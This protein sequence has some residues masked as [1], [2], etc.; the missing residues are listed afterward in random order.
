M[1]AS[2]GWL[3]IGPRLQ[4]SVDDLIESWRPIKSLRPRDRR[5]RTYSL[6]NEYLRPKDVLETYIPVNNVSIE[7]TQCHDVIN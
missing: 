3:I 2:C 7:P 5:L 4:A 6:S 1:I